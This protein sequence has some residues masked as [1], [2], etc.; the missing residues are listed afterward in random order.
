M[1]ES[2]TYN[3]VKEHMLRHHENNAFRSFHRDD[4]DTAAI[5]A[6]GEAAAPF[7][8]QLM[9]DFP[10]EACHFGFNMIPRLIKPPQN[11][12]DRM[13]TEACKPVGGG[14]FMGLDVSKMQEI[15]KAWG[16]QIGAFPNEP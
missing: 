8:F 12:I 7:L 3:A 15:Y 1:S 14:A 5:E 2:V 4:A 6:M 9:Q 16:Q 10:F 13:N 11:I